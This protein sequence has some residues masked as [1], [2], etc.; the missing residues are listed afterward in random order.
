GGVDKSEA[1][2]PVQSV[3][4][5]SDPFASHAPKH[6]VDAPPAEVEPV[7]AAATMEAEPV[8]MSSSGAAAAPAMATDAFAQLPPE[9]A[10]VH[11][12]AQRFARLLVDEIKLYNQV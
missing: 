6:V 1:A 10:D 8:P 11:R 7:P 4:S 3:S 9:D 2:P 5:F 12:K